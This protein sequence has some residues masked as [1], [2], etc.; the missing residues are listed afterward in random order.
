MVCWR[1]SQNLK[2]PTLPPPPSSLPQA[3][4]FVLSESASGYSIFE[5]KEF[6]EICQAAQKLQDAVT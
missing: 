4:T 1:R 2:K 6:D 5:V 3:T